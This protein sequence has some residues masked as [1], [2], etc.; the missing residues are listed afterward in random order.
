MTES[1]ESGFHIVLDDFMDWPDPTDYNI[2]DFD[3]PKPSDYFITSGDA[4]SKATVMVADMW[5]I[6][7]KAR[8]QFAK[9]KSKSHQEFIKKIWAFSG[10]CQSFLNY[11]KKLRGEHIF[12]ETEHRDHKLY[13]IPKDPRKKIQET[14]D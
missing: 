9:S 13:V 5:Q 3:L 14:I 8:K 4:V 2:K 11:L 7:G 10:Q 12:L 6:A 1:V